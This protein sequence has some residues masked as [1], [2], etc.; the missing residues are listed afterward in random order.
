[1]IILYF[2]YLFLVE[3]NVEIVDVSLIT[4][5]SFRTIL[6]QGAIASAARHIQ[7]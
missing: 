5:V 7:F 1:M 4:F 6:V 3:Q 2:F